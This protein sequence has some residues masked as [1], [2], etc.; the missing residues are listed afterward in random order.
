MKSFG[1]F[2]REDF[3]DVNRETQTAFAGAFCSQAAGRE[4]EAQCRQRHG[5]CSADAGGQPID[6]QAVAESVWPDEIGGGEAAEAA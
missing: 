4:R 5:R 6:L 2:W 3:D 1:R